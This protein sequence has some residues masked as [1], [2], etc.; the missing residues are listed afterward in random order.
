MK[1]CSEVRK[2]ENEIL[3]ELVSLKFAQIRI[4]FDE[5]FTTSGTY[6][7]SVIKRRKNMIRQQGVA[8][9]VGF[10]I[11][12]LVLCR[13]SFARSFAR[14]RFPRSF[15]ELRTPWKACGAARYANGRIVRRGS[16][17]RRRKP[18]HTGG[19][20]RGRRFRP[21]RLFF[22]AMLF[23]R[24]HSSKDSQKTP[25]TKSLWIRMNT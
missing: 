20:L 9:R 6:V 5:N 22:C 19:A 16:L 13:L 17:V 12:Y 8:Q 10:E 14:S 4:L 25:D 2:A 1:F 15:F 23:F 11:R 21:Q 7:W 24:A 3:P 18:T